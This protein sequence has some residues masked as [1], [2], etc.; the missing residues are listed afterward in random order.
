MAAPRK[1]CVPA[2]SQ[3]LSWK[4]GK[5]LRGLKKLK[6]ILVSYPLLN[7]FLSAIDK[8][9]A[10]KMAHHSRTPNASCLVRDNY[11]VLKKMLIYNEDRNNRENRPYLEAKL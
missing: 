4:A 1:S 5:F 7:T 10:K 11:K 2:C 9:I 8:F 6:R 3:K